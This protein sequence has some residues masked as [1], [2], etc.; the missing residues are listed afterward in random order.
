MR[1]KRGKCLKVGTSDYI[2][3]LDQSDVSLNVVPPVYTRKTFSK[4]RFRWI[5]KVLLSHLNI[6]D[7]LI[8]PHF[9]PVLQ[10]RQSTEY[11]DQITVCS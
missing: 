8:T 2:L 7:S 5:L 6:R 9:L 11:C 10:F 1:V 4:C 3:K